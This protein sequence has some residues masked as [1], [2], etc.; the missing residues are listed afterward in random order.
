MKTFAIDD[1]E[2]VSMC[3][4]RMRLRLTGHQSLH[5]LGQQLGVFSAM[6]KI[7]SPVHTENSV[8]KASETTAT[9]DRV[10]LKNKQLTLR[11]MV[12]LGA[13]AAT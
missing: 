4:A 11:S 5:A 1:H 3:Y 2:N 13:I 6:P 7:A 9:I 8:A 10:L 12:A